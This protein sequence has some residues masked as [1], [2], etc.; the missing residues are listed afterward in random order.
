MIHVCFYVKNLLLNI[1]VK[2]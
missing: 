2:F 1:A